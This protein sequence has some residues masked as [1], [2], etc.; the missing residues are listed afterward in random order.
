MLN[1]VLSHL[2]YHTLRGSLE[3]R[4]C[5]SGFARDVVLAL[6]VLSEFRTAAVNIGVE[7]TAVPAKNPYPSDGC[8]F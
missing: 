7:P 4:S 8:G 3:N 2:G 5:N 6:V 1:F